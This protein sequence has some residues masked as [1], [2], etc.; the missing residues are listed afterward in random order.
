MGT[1]IELGSPWSTILWLT[2]SSI[3]MCTLNLVPS[4]C[5]PSLNF[6]G[7]VSRL[8]GTLTRHRGLTLAAVLTVARL[9]HVDPVRD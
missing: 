6:V 4:S 7:P 9:P 1:V 8:T 2:M 5:L 3:I